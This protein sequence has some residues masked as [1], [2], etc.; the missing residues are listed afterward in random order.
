MYVFLPH[1]L[2][3]KKIPVL[4]DE[5][6][7]SVIPPLF[8]THSKYDTRTDNGCGRLEQKVK[9]T[10]ERLRQLHPAKPHSFMV[11]LSEGLAAYYSL[12]SFLLILII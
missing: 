6:F 2:K 11:S 9:Q 12:S 5:R 10:P 4:K 1:L 7:A 8:R 3:T